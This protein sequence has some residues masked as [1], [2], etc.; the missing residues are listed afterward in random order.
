MNSSLY[1]SVIIGA[2]AAG[3]MT[4]IQAQRLGLKIL[5]L[6][7]REK[8]GA[9]ILM[10]GGTRCNVTN[11]NVSEKDF[12]S[13][14]PRLVRNILRAFPSAKTLAFFSELGVELL[15][16]AGGKFFP[17]THSSHTVLNAL[18]DEISRNSIPLLSGKEV[19]EVFF[20]NN[21]FLARGPGFEYRAKTAVFCTGGLSYPSTGSDGKGYSLARAFGHHPIRTS[22]ALTPLM[23]DD[24]LWKTLTGLSLPCR[25]SLLTNGK[26]EAAYT[27]DF[28]FTHFGFSGPTAL[29]IS[30]HWERAADKKASVIQVNFLPQENEHSL[31]E[32]FL[33]QAR[34]FPNRAVKR[35]F[36]GVLPERMTVAI[37][38]K[39]GIAPD[40][41]L[42]H[43]RAEERKSLIE[44]IVRYVLPVK[45]VYGYQKA[46]VTAG[47]IDLKEID[48][49]SMES[50]LRPGLFLA[51]EILDADGR[52]GGFNFQW[53]WATGFLAAQGVEKYLHKT[54]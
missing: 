37:L 51:G 13:S 5:L 46:E 54:A 20:E 52:I 48:Y 18:V 44:N 42:N 2:G 10:S 38:E 53:A 1:D 31:R 4:A 23:S 50:K 8:I 39:T 21:I 7:S 26:E 19:T 34:Q 47:G 11:Q 29:N 33:A 32:R 25:V 43:I 35:V 17:A 36:S 49:R 12:A 41:P 22:P 24:R 6:D 16:E 14:E 40:Q 27:G 3:L 9:K 15:P 45:G 28:L 30:R